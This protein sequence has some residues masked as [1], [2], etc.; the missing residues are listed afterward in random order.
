MD[1]T[2]HIQRAVTL[3]GGTQQALADKAGLTQAGVHWLLSG[4][5][6]VSAE[7]AIRIETATN[8]EVTR[9]D[10]RPDIFSEQ[11]S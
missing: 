4:R 11:A 3:C 1:H 7:T 9:Q 10:L 2:E 8:G 5:G 6:K